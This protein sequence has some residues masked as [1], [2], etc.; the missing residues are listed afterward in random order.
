[1]YVFPKVSSS[2]VS[3]SFQ[4]SDPLVKLLAPI[5]SCK[6]SKKDSSWS[7]C[8]D[9]FASLLQVRHAQQH[10][11]VKGKCYLRDWTQA[12]QENSMSSGLEHF[13]C[14]HGLPSL[15]PHLWP[16]GGYLIPEKKL[17]TWFAGGC[18]WYG[19]S[20]PET[21]CWHRSI[22]DELLNSSILNYQ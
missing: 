19:W 12:G 8:W 6:L 4:I 16:Y 20:Q 21:E 9:H 3:C 1:M 2:Q 15:T 7:C 13:Y 5:C 11:S 18:M 14:T 17:Q 22:I 10:I